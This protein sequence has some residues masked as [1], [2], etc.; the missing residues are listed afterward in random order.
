MVGDDFDPTALGINL[1]QRRRSCGQSALSVSTAAPFC[2]ARL[3][4]ATAA[5]WRVD[6]SER[7]ARGRKA[8]QIKADRERVSGGGAMKETNRATRFDG[9]KME[10]SE[11]LPASCPP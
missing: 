7:C 4:G 11:R 2:S 1:N 3:D 5:N 8:T 6:E 9:A 10:E